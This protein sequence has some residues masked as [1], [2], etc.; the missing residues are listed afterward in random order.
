MAC[1]LKTTDHAVVWVANVIAS[2]YGEHILNVTIEEDTDNGKF[3]SIG[4][5]I[6]MD[7]FKEAQYN[8]TGFKAK[9]EQESAN[10]N[11]YVRIYEPGDAWMLYNVPIIEY[12]FNQEIQKELHFYNA[13][14]DTVRAYQLHKMDRLEMSDLCFEGTPEAG[15]DL[16]INAATG[17]LVVG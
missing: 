13:A 12:E 5:F 2:E 4:D 10:G 11:W 7:N 15:R 9:I 6:N 16:T 1:D 3:I 17:K 8:G 14:G